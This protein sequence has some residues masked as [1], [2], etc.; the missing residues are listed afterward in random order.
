MMP[1]QWLIQTLFVRFRRLDPTKFKTGDLVEAQV[2][3]MGVPLKG[4]KVKLLMVL[5]A[6]TL[7]DC[8]Q[9]MVRS[10]IPISFNNMTLIH[11]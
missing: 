11:N 3:L 2:L 4:G 1:I 9:S 10:H 8:Q 6:L 7:L 5:W